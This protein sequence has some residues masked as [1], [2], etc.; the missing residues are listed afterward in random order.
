LAVGF[1][2][3][4]KRK[5][6]FSDLE[7][8][9][10]PTE[11]TIGNQWV[12]LE[13]HLVCGPPMLQTIQQGQACFHIGITSMADIHPNQWDKIAPKAKADHQQV[14]PRSAK[15]PIRTVHRHTTSSTTAQGKA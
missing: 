14:A 8:P 11:F 10:F 2:A 6:T 4:N 12:S 5:T 9:E 1:E 7:Q 13:R 3:H 15:L